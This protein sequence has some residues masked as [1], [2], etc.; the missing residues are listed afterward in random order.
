MELAFVTSAADSRYD[1]LAQIARY[2]GWD[3][4]E[5]VST[6]AHAQAEKELRQLALESEEL[7]QMQQLLS[8]LIY[9]NPALRADAD[10]L[11][12]NRLGQAGLWPHA[13]SGDYPI[14]LLRLQDDEG[15]PLLRQILRAHHYWRNRDLR[16]SLVIL[17]H[18]ETGYT[19]E[20]QGSVSQLLNRNG[21]SQWLQSPWRHL[22]AARRRSGRSGQRASPD[23]CTRHLGSGARFA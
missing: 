21:H 17:N 1:V 16:I 10:T 18:E 7:A 4:I 9:P 15:L 23:G 19:Q 14:L 20:L 3:A 12:A 5:R 6:H 13:I 11:A 8:A 22:S 2:D